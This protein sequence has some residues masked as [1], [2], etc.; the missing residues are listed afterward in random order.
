MLNAGSPRRRLLVMAITVAGFLSAY[1]V[2]TFDANRVTESVSAAALTPAE[3][4]AR[5]SVSATAYCKGSVTK[6][7]APVQSGIAAADPS[8]LPVGSVV[9]VNSPDP[10]YDGIYTI[11]DTG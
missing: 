11:L 8:I 3:P 5:L 2:T 7:G 10:R 1:E 4:G 9:H 6:S